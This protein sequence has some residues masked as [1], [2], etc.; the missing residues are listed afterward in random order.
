MLN[1]VAERLSRGVAAD[2]GRGQRIEDELTPALE[3]LGASIELDGEHVSRCERL[4]C[5]ETLADDARA[6]SDLPVAIPTRGEHRRVH[7]AC[8]RCPDSSVRRIDDA[9]IVRGVEDSWPSCCI[10]RPGRRNRNLV[11]VSDSTGKRSV[12]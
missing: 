5:E 9:R 6:R 7:H 2:D 4:A 12:D 11:L 1:D 3:E 8:I 10:V